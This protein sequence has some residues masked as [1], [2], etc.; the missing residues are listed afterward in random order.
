M[1]TNGRAAAKQVYPHHE[2]TAPRR[3]PVPLDING[4]LLQSCTL[5]SATFVV[6]VSKQVA[7][8]IVK[9]RKGEEKAIL[10]AFH[11]SAKSLIPSEL[12]PQSFRLDTA[13]GQT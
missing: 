11:A 5:G 3:L 10:S 8:P 6:K 13:I 1:P 7:L 4:V 12:L 9:N 2:V